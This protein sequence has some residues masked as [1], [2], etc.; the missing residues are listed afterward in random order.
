MGKQAVPAFV[1]RL[2]QPGFN[3]VATVSADSHR[4][5]HPVGEPKDGLHPLHVTSKPCRVQRHP[6]HHSRSVLAQFG[7][8]PKSKR[9]LAASDPGEAVDPLAAL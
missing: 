5:L 2:A 7:L 4:R 1:P 8:T 9:G 3:G 6:D